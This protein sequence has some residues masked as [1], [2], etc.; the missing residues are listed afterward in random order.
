MLFIVNPCSGRASIKSH[1][2][3]AI[4]HFT[5]A[6][7]L[8]TVYV[9]QRAGEVADV[10]A[11]LGQGYDRI[12]ASG[13]DGTINETLNGL[14]RLPTQIPLGIIPAG[15]TNDYAYSLGISSS[16][17]EA[18]EIAVS[19][20]LFA[21]D[22][23]S[24]NGR[25]FTYVAAFGLFTEITYETSQDL[26]NVLGVAAYALEGARRILDIKTYHISLEYDG[27]F[28]DD[29][30]IIGLFSNSVSVAGF[31]T[32]FDGAKLDDGLLEITLIRPP[33]TLADIQAIINILLDFERLNTVESDFLTVVTTKK[34]R[35]SCNEPLKWTVDGES[36]GVF[37]TSDIENVHHAAIVVTGERK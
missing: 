3:D 18:A 23:G 33:K 19:D 36:G 2:L 4:D 37:L 9:T 1:L 17:V 28:I 11:S 25:Y 13:G 31:R 27:G 8:V 21:I 30:V 32:A 35:I 20:N 15:T 34:A 6:G 24:F 22:V 29:E 10:V 26:K 7:F 5:S 12:V 14:M 16:V